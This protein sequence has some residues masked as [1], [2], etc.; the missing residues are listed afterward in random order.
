MGGGGTEGTGGRGMKGAGR[1]REMGVGGRRGKARLASKEEK[2]LLTE[3][4]AQQQWEQI[5]DERGEE[6]L[7]WCHIP[8]FTFPLF[9]DLIP[10]FL[11]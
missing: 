6:S 3:L 9:F 4:V 2:R 11:F 8:F 1:R 10:C 7:T 5:V